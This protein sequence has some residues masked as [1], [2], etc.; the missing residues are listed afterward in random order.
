MELRNKKQETDE[1]RY[2]LNNCF[3]LVSLMPLSLASDGFLVQNKKNINQH[4]TH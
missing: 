1:G 2:L 4:T 3:A